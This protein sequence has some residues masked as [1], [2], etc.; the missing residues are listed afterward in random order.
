[1][2]L[3]NK[4]FQTKQYIT[5]I[6]KFNSN[7]ATLTKPLGTCLPKFLLQLTLTSTEEVTMTKRNEWQF[8]FL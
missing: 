8:K 3:I 1:M 4:K 6:R 2:K 5:D 7:R